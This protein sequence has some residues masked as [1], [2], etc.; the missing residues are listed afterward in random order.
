MSRRR[1]QGWV[2]CSLGARADGSLRLR[3]RWQGKARSVATGLEDTPEHRRTLEPLR[4]LVAATLRA[5]Q[6]PMPVLTKAFPR[7]SDQLGASALH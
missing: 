1:R 2:G 4:D 6:D 3:F 7:A 5:G